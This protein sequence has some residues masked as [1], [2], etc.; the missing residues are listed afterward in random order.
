M[1]LNFEIWI[2]LL[3]KLS[4]HSLGPSLLLHAL[5][6]HTALLLSTIN[7]RKVLFDPSHLCNLN[8]SSIKVFSYVLPKSV[9]NQ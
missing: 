6:N 3:I 2:D 5:S 9:Q 4:S 8:I 7:R 1:S